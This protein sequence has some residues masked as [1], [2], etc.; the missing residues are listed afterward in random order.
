MTDEPEFTPDDSGDEKVKNDAPHYRWYQVW[1][2]VFAQPEV[3]TFEDVLAD[4]NITYWRAGSWL[5]IANLVRVAPALLFLWAIFGR[6]VL[7]LLLIAA[8]MVLAVLG[9]AE[10]LHIT[11][12]YLVGGIGGARRFGLRHFFYGYAAVNAPLYIVGTLVSL[13]V[14]NPLFFYAMNLYRFVQEGLLLRAA[15]GVG[16]WRVILT[17]V[18][19]VAVEAMLLNALLSLLIEILI[20]LLS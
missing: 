2:K 11:L 3:T 19:V 16:W 15:H 4:V 9:A 18:S 5:L 14:A 7:P 12:L 20:S 8:G 10:V 6:E 1:G 17:V 13:L